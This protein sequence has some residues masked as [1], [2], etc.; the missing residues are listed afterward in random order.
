M[1]V[2]T[3]KSLTV[4]RVVPAEPA[5]VFEAW[6]QPEIAI[7]WSCPYPGGA[8]EYT[9]DLRVGGSY[10]L[11]MEVEGER[12]TAFGTYR[13]ID[14]PNRVVYTWDWEEEAHACGE[15]LVEVDFRAVPEGTEVRVT[16]SGFAT[17]EDRQGHDEG[18]NACVDNLVTLLRG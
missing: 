11:R 9:A 13:E 6:T 14:P 16:H 15:T 3:G 12:Y 1:S 7:R 18:W 4:T 17:E 8:Q 5:R 10:R 2:A